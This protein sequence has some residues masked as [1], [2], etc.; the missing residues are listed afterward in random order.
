M[1]KLIL[2]LLLAAGTMS[3]FA[4]GTVNFGNGVAFTTATDQ[5]RLVYLGSIGAGK[6]LIGTQFA[7]QLYYGPSAANL[8][9]VATT[10]NLFRAAGTTSPGTWSSGGTRT[11]TGFLAGDTVMLQV[12]AWDTT[13]GATYDAA[14]T[15]GASQVFSYVVPAA[16]SLASAFY[17]NL[18]GFAVVVPEPSTFAFAGI[19]LL[20]LIMARRRK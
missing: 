12:R 13:T 10:G 15:R 2:S 14:T 16:G 19:G 20:G 6:E 3:A 18:R 4:Q 11:L 1:K 5:S 7:A 8:Q 17:K 9:A